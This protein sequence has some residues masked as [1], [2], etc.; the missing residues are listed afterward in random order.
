LIATT[1]PL[2]GAV[3]ITPGFFIFEERLSF[4]DLFP[5]LHQHGRAHSDVICAQNGDMANVRGLRNVLFWHASD[6][7]IKSFSD[8]KHVVSKYP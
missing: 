6:R 8:S 1:V 3:N 5:F 2:A 7:E 4:N